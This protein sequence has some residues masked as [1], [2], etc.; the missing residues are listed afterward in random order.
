[1]GNIYGEVIG[2]KWGKLISC[3]WPPWSQLLWTF[4]RSSNFSD[5]IILVEGYGDRVCG[6]CGWV[7]WRKQNERGMGRGVGR[8]CAEPIL[9]KPES[10]RPCTNE[11]GVWFSVKSRMMNRGASLLTTPPSPERVS[12]GMRRNVRRR[13]PSSSASRYQ[14]FLAVYPQPLKMKSSYQRPLTSTSIFIYL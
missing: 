5:A 4:G 13:Y 11:S 14:V 1:M 12:P 3:H 8:E 9:A 6:L 10:V 7:G 2:S